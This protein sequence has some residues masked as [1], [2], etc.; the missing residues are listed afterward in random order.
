MSICVYCKNNQKTF[1]KR[2]HVIP[3]AFGKFQSNFILNDRTKKDETVCDD[4]NE[5]LGRE[6]ENFF[7]IDSYE[8]YIGR[9]RHMNLQKSANRKRI[10]ITLAEG[11][12]VGIKV[13]LLAGHKIKILPQI[14]L[15]KKDSTWNY[16]LLKE[17]TNIELSNYDLSNSA[18]FR[19]ICLSDSES[20][21]AFAGLG[22][23]FKKGENLPVPQEK[24]ILC[25]VE[26]QND[27]LIYRTVAKIAF[28]YF[29]FH[30][31]NN[32]I[33]EEYFDDIRNF[34]LHGVG[35][36][37]VVDNESILANE[38]GK[39]K[40]LKGHVVV[41]TQDNFGKIIVQLSLFNEFRYTITIAKYLPQHIRNRISLDFGHFF[42]ID[43]NKIENITKSSLLIP[44]HKKI[45]LPK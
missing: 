28:N 16:F 37:V 26:W 41:M 35:N 24:D 39:K 19:A 44:P 9:N 2:E 42:N 22:I 29:I 3:Q 10:V 18:N 40:V 30:N 15:Q 1:N 36:L 23:P 31:N 43:N 17:L 6:L 33:S 8:G 34:I 12:Y 25:K 27:K 38:Q 7:A 21:D 20:K 5:S 45:W 13:E 32:L 11:F 14:G 4:C